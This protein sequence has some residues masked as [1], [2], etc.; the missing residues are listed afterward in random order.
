MECKWQGLG[1]SSQYSSFSLGVSF[2]AAVVLGSCHGSLE[3][4]VEGYILRTIKRRRV[5][6]LQDTA[7]VFERLLY[8]VGL[9][10][11]FILL[12]PACLT[13]AHTVPNSRMSK[14]AKASMPSAPV[15]ALLCCALSAVHVFPPLINL[16]LNFQ[17]LIAP[18]MYRMFP[19]FGHAFSLPTLLSRCPL[20]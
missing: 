6:Q 10:H 8:L 12:C 5:F 16:S 15:S 17:F 2:Q 11:F 3:F 19:C 9:L 13:Q 18:F 7:Q 4:G 14:E 20:N 1:S